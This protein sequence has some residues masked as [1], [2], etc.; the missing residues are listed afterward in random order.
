MPAKYRHAYRDT[1]KALEHWLDMNYDSCDRVTGSPSEYLAEADQIMLERYGVGIGR[2]V[3]H[4]TA[5]IARYAYYLDVPVETCI[6]LIA[7][8]LEL[9]G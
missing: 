7:Q 5:I 3:N 6:D 9:K 8:R 1:L 2:E 4:G